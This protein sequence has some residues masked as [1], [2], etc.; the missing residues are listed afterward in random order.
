[1]DYQMEL[2]FEDMN[3]PGLRGQ[4]DEEAIRM[5]REFEP[6]A[7]QN[8]PRGYC[9]C[10]SEG[11][12]SRVLGHLMRRAG[13]RHFYKC[14][15]AFVSKPALHGCHCEPVRRLAWQSVLRHIYRSFCDTRLTIR[16][17]VKN[18]AATKARNTSTKTSDSSEAM[19]S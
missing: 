6:L 11:K 4:P 14:V 1:M 8:D 16:S 3:Q 9:V 13:V 5:I 10:T 19:K 17:A 15:S 12:D 18:I 2:S 7:I